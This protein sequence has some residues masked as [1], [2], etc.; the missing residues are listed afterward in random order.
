M[1]PDP[2]IVQQLPPGVTDL[3][4]TDELI[5]V[6]L[7]AR[8]ELAHRYADAK[9]ILNWGRIVFPDKF[10]LPFCADLH[11]YMVSIRHAELTC[12]EA[13]RNHAKSTIRCFLI[14]IFQAL[15]EPETY[16][17]YLNVQA[18]GIK[19]FSVNLSIRIEIE[20]NPMVR[21]LYGNQVGLDKWTDGQFQ[22]RNGVIFSAVGASQSIRGL[23]FRNIRPDQIILDDFFDEEEIYNDD[24]TI[25]KNSWFWSSLYPARAKSRRCGVHVQGTAISTVDL[26][27]ELKT[28]STEKGG[29]WLCRTFRACDMEKKTVLW[30]ELNTYDQLMA[31]RHDMPLVIWAREMQ[32]ERLDS[33]TSIIKR[34]WLQDWEYDPI[35][36]KFLGERQGAT[37]AYLGG[38]LGCDPSI[39]KHEE[40]DYTGYA[41]VLKAQPSGGALPVY[42]IEAIAQEHLSLQ[43]RVDKAKEYTLNRSAER[44]ATRVI[45][46]TISG[47][48]DFGDK[49]MEAV[50]VPCTLVD[51]VKDKIVNLEKKSIVF[52]NHRIFL[53]KNI[54]EELKTTL[55]NQLINTHAPHD[56][57]R[58]ALLLTIEDESANWSTWI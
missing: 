2:T 36:L 26:M 34:E 33:A 1:T 43:N 37:L 30:S 23:N 14:P 45:V 24:A 12:T 15:N 5:N 47:F 10:R 32:N 40:N 3:V 48:Q 56:D 46:E 49:V 51:H 57:I 58:D 31:D 50:A 17:H 19:S 16:N 25:K 54:P 7:E 28:K 53:N 9:D 41:F 39:G 20:Q 29:R 11:G 35:D 42:Y 18:T 6:G 22:L 13:P 52:Q 27:E 55:V 21:A 38:I 44:P 4:T 8:V